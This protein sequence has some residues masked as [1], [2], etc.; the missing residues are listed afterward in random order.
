MYAPHI[1]RV[2]LIVIGFAC[3]WCGRP[4]GRNVYQ[5]GHGMT[6]MF[7]AMAV[8]AFIGSALSVP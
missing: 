4:T 1:C 6:W 5:Y 3:L 2:I 7:L 8:L